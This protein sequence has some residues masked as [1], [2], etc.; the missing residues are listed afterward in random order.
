[1]NALVA[2]GA[3]AAW[4]YSVVAT[5]APGLLPADT[6]NVYYE[7]AAVI[8]TLIL[9]GRFLEAR[10]K[11]R[12]SEA[13]RHLMGLQPKTARVVRNGETVE[14]AIADV[15]AGDIL[16]VRPGEKIA[17]DGVVFEGNSYVDES[18]ITGEPVPVQKADGAEVVGGTINKTGAFSFRAT[19][20]GADTVLAQIIRMVEQAQGAKLPIQSLVDRVTAWFVPAV[21]AIALATFLVWLVFGPDPALTFALVNGVA[22]LIIACP[23]AMGLATPTSIMVGTGRAAEMGVLFRKGKPCRRCATPKSSRSTRPVL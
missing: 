8:V 5:F 3:F 15:R 2:I 9:L 20:V 22:V 12:T 4:G 21:M 10:A 16:V 7:A 6:A 19:K 18:M 13:I 14:I 17:V 23:C 1:M 11:G